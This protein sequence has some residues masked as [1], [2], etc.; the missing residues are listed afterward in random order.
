M[1]PR[2]IKEQLPP[3]MKSCIHFFTAFLYTKLI[4]P[5]PQQPKKLSKAAKAKAKAKADAEKAKADAE[6]AKAIEADE[7]II[8]MREGSCSGQDEDG[9][10]CVCGW[11][12]SIKCVRV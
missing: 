5:P 12:A 2:Y 4:E 11:V 7:D 9:A 6:M 8:D 1:L 3:H 10:R